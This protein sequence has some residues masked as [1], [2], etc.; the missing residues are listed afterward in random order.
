M[1]QPLVTVIC[2]CYN[3]GTFA[4]EAIQSV[5][6]QTHPAVQLVVVDDSSTDASAD[7]I[8]DCIA[9]HPDVVF[10]SL[11]ANVGY[12]KAFNK[13]L[14]HA[15]GEYLI[16]LAADDVLLPGRIS[17]GVATLTNAGPQYGVHF[18]DAH[19]IAEDGSNLYTHSKR[20]PHHAIPQGDIYKD[21]IERFFICSPTMMF[22]RAVIESLGGYDEALAYEDFD[23]WIRSS[24]SFYYCYTP[25]V[26]VKKR[27]VRNSMSHRQFSVLSSQ[28][29]STYKVCEKI[30]ELNQSATEQRA[31]GRRI[32]YEMRV[33]LRLLHLPLTVRYAQLYFRNS[34]L[35]YD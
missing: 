33:A 11:T 23:F 16:D 1:L 3:Q 4:R 27:V 34:R 32:Q 8:R 10:L 31:L 21:L 7:V 9:G 14:R 13:A 20:F 28:L 2:V 25:E 24:R 22:R 19:W 18:S 29:V 12:C 35:R 15:K 26:L 6:S 17:A 30:M 5:L